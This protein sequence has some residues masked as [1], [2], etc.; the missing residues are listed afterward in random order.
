[1]GS[2]STSPLDVDTS[3]LKGRRKNFQNFFLWSIKYLDRHNK[4]LTISNTKKVIADGMPCSG[5]C[6]G[7]EIVIAVKNPKF[8]QVYVHEF[9]HMQQAVEEAECWKDCDKFWNDLQKQKLSLD[10][11]AC[12]LDIIK[13]ER[14]CERRALLL[15]K[16]YNLFDP[17]KYAQ[18]ANLYLYYYHYV[19]VK[20]KWKYGMNKLY[21][22]K[23]CDKMPKKLL[24]NSHF[25]TIDMD[26]MLEFD[27][28]SKRK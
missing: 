14:D 11:W 15:N 21:Q 7:I 22:S 12:A 13:L 26:I 25:S 19:F 18:E 17:E 8:E 16:K 5:W 4:K 6:D 2:T 20:R 28:I 27:K 1:M 3:F 24:P 9:A 23:L 10:S